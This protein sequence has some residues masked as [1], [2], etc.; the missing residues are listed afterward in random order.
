MIDLG[1]PFNISSNHI[2]RQGH[3]EE[4]KAVANMVRGVSEKGEVIL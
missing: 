3:C 4:G 1:L 2:I